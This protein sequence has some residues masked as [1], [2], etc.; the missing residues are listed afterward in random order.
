[1]IRRAAGLVALCSFQRNRLDYLI[2]HRPLLPPIIVVR[3]L[4][5]SHTARYLIPIL[6]KELSQTTNELI[7]ILRVIFLS[8]Y[9][10]GYASASAWYT[11]AMIRVIQKSANLPRSHTLIIYTRFESIAAIE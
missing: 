6:S 1:M 5:T 3:S 9:P 7:L 4:E 8:Q 2:L 10:F 11:A